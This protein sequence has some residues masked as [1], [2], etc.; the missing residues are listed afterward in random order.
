VG[1]EEAAG[2]K[3][4]AIALGACSSRFGAGPAGASGSAPMALQGYTTG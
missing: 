2:L 4:M 3:R 1:E